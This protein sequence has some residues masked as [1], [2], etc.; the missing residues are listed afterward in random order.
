MTLFIRVRRR[1]LVGRITP[2]HGG[3]TGSNPVG[4][5]NLF[6]ILRGTAAI[7]VPVVS[8]QRCAAMR[9]STARMS[10]LP[11]PQLGSRS[12]GVCG[13]WSATEGE[14]DIGPFPA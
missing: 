8:R 1:P 9:S 3:N 7:C 5:A 2:S 12:F 4:D 13:A 14:V 11:R 6:N 10:R